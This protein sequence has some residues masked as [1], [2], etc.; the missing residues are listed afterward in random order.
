MKLKTTRAI[1]GIAGIITVVLLIISL[2]TCNNNVNLQRRNVA[3]YGKI[4]SLYGVVDQGK[5]MLHAALNRIDQDS[6]QIGRYSGCIDQC[7]ILSNKM[8][9]VLKQAKGGG[10]EK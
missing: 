6:I 3:L 8:A 1:L 2:T 4:D 9:D 10:D 5:V 7:M